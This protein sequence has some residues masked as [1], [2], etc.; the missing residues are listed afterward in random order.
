MLNKNDA[1]EIH[2][3][4]LSIDQG[5]TY[6][7]II[8]FYILGKNNVQLLLPRGFSIAR[9]RDSKVVFPAPV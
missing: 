7:V 2:H 9:C 1:R 8:K 3:E 4:L 5:R 6:V